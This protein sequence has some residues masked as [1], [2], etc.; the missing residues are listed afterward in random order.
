MA[1]ARVG[2]HSSEGI[3]EMFRAGVVIAAVTG[4][5]ENDEDVACARALRP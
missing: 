4:A 2:R 3:Q 5:A 1:G